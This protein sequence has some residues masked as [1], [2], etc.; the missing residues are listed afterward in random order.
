MIID[1]EKNYLII[2]NYE[3]SRINISDFSKG[4][5]NGFG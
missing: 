5:L 1:N 2:L 4:M 3:N